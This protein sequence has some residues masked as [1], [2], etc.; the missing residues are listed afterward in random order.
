MEKKAN[1][2]QKSIILQVSKEESN[3]DLAIT[4]LLKEKEEI[5]SQI[6]WITSDLKNLEKKQNWFDELFAKYKWLAKAKN[7]EYQDIIKSIK[8]KS[9]TI[10]KI[11]KSKPINEVIIK[12]SEDIDSIIDLQKNRNKYYENFIKA[13]QEQ[14]ARINNIIKIDEL[15]NN[16]IEEVEKDIY[17]MTI[18]WIPISEEE[19]INMINELSKKKESINLNQDM[20]K[21]P[22]NKKRYD[23]ISKIEQKINKSE[24]ISNI[25]DKKEEG[26]D[27]EWRH[28]DGIIWNWF[29]TE[30]KKIW[31]YLSDL[32]EDLE[33]TYKIAEKWFRGNKPEKDLEYISSLSDKYIDEVDMYYVF[34]NDEYINKSE[35]L[36]RKK[37]RNTSKQLLNPAHRIKSVVSAISALHIYKHINE[38]I[39]INKIWIIKKQIEDYQGIIQEINQ[40]TITTNNKFDIIYKIEDN[41]EKLDEIFIKLDEIFIKNSK[42]EISI[43]GAISKICK[44]IAIQN[45]INWYLDKEQA[46]DSDKCDLQRMIFDHIL[47]YT[48]PKDFDKN[49]PI[50]QDIHTTITFLIK[51]IDE[52]IDKEIEEGKWIANEEKIS[53]MDNIRSSYFG[54]ETILWIMINQ[55][56][57]SKFRIDVTIKDSKIN[58]WLDDDEIIND[59]EEIADKYYWQIKTQKISN[60]DI[61]IKLW[62]TRWEDIVINIWTTK[63]TLSTIISI[64]KKIN[65]NKIQRDISNNQNNDDLIHYKTVEIWNHAFVIPYE[66][67]WVLSITL[68]DDKSLS[69]DW[70]S[71][72]SI[73]DEIW[74]INYEKF[75]AWIFWYICKNND[76]SIDI[77]NPNEE[78]LAKNIRENRIKENN[79]IIKKQDT[80]IKIQDYI[81]PVENEDN[82]I[83]QAVWLSQKI[84]KYIYDK[85][86]IKIKIENIQR[87]AN[88]SYDTRCFDFERYEKDYK[89]SKNEASRIEIKKRANENWRKWS[90]IYKINEIENNKIDKY[91]EKKENLEEGEGQIQSI[92]IPDNL[93][94]WYKFLKDNNIYILK[95][96]KEKIENFLLNSKIDNHNYIWITSKVL[97]KKIISG[98]KIIKK[99]K[100][101]KPRRSIEISRWWRWIMCMVDWKFLVVDI[102]SY[103][104]EYKKIRYKKFN[105][106]PNY[107]KDDI[108]DEE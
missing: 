65:K 103:N 52:K 70:M 38:N 23:K 54:L 92:N 100:H 73:I 12:I 22:N 47:E 74:E 1:I 91:D 29:F 5:L 60:D 104:D 21:S 99:N 93:E 9:N 80:K 105:D 15:K 90:Y 71:K 59:Y 19:K 41:I 10:T 62:A 3:Y 36:N 106:N 7:D 20:I 30:F 84:S 69:I 25:Y 66:I 6:K 58:T 17:D 37:L 18:L 31:N 78:I 16:V 97:Y 57:I 87:I 88:K 68:H 8:E 77:K 11:W 95:S 72:Y 45:I 75:R 98:N 50:L 13:K 76:N 48:I 28:I 94:S 27:I 85:S 2:I 32:E 107:N 26:M 34:V 86:N 79:K 89:I 53:E 67:M 96:N 35:N 102:C 24:N 56:L 49:Y 63:N 43:D 64:W 61:V 108:L 81:K 14:I 51:K 82:T 101:D 39:D 4:N 33:K 44:Y 55:L 46:I 40:V 42:D 83:K